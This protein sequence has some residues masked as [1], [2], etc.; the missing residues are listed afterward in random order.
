M[1]KFFEFLARRSTFFKGLYAT[2]QDFKDERPLIERIVETEM[3]LRVPVIVSQ[4]LYIIESVDLS[5]LEP[6]DAG[7]RPISNL[8]HRQRRWLIEHIN[9]SLLE[10]KYPQYFPKDSYLNSPTTL[11]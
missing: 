4:I 7:V 1:K 11:L 8:S 2:E 5:A 3:A 6:L 10:E 9:K